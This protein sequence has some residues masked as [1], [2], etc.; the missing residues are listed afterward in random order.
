MRCGEDLDATTR[1]EELQHDA[2]QC[3]GI[4]TP[5]CNATIS[6]TI[7]PLVLYPVCCHCFCHVAFHHFLL[8][9]FT[10]S[11]TLLCLLRYSR[12]YSLF[13]LRY[14]NPRLSL[15]MLFR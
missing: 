8:P 12:P 13:L 10:V 7:R 4:S 14:F 5:R 15:P 3:Q 1:C 9:R 11:V 6:R 2:M